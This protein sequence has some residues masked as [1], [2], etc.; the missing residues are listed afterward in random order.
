MNNGP[1]NVTSKY[2]LSPLAQHDRALETA[3][4]LLDLQVGRPSINFE[5]RR[6][7]GFTE[8]Q[9]AEVIREAA[10]LAPVR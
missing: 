2:G 5:L 1:G 8:G 6:Q 4:A 10:A 7:H 3:N 9:A